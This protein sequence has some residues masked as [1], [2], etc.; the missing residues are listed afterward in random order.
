[1]SPYRLAAHLVS[2][3]TIYSVMV[4]T[5]LDLLH[6]TPLLASASHAAQRAGRLVRS[7]VLP[8]SALVAVTATSGA[9]VAGGIERL[10]GAALPFHGQQLVEYGGIGTK[11]CACASRPLALATLA[12]PRRSWAP[13]WRSWAQTSLQAC[14]GQH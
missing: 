8:F 7:C 3:F 13:L 11:E 6:P 4:W 9:F 1:M 14:L 2:A 10:F 5:T 12:P